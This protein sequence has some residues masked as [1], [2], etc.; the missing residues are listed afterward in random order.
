[1]PALDRILAHFREQADIC[2]RLGSPFTSAVLEATMELLAAHDPTVE[3]VARFAGDPKA[4]ALAL[5]VAGA[6]HRIAQDGRNHRLAELYAH[7]DALRARRSAPLLSSAL[8][9]N[10]DRLENY[11]AHAP[12]T[13]EAARSAML[14]GGFLTVAHACR[15]PLAV[16]EIGASAGLNLLFDRYRYDF[17]DWSWG[18]QD[19]RLTIAAV[20]E[21]SRPP[22]ANP[23]VAARRGCDCRPLDLR[24]DEARRRLQSYVWADQKDRIERL[25]R[26]I[27]TALADPPR[28]ER[29][30]AADWL[31]TQLAQPRPG[32]V[33]VIAHSIVW[34]YLGAEAQERITE[35]LMQRG[36]KASVEAPLAWLRL[37]TEPGAA[38]PGLRLTLWPGGE[39][40]LLGL[41]DY[42]GRRMTWLDQPRA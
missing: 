12:Q 38:R 6:L 8:R 20:W 34:R 28:V 27:A 30:D 9:A 37:E 5:R 35:E 13:N 23:I 1:M 3:P 16:L 11:L 24:E 19:A 18:A 21:G 33:T 4:G 36:A 41:G 22:D 7:A 42:H 32:R 40:R 15:L 31:E 26:A 17:G 29:A 2:T 25:D 39:E 14:L 10:S